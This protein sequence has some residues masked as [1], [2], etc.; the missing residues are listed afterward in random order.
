[1][2]EHLSLK[3][4]ARRCSEIVEVLK[5]SNSLPSRLYITM[6]PPK[7]RTL[8]MALLE[9]VPMNNASLPV[10]TNA[11]RL[12]KHQI[13]ALS[14]EILMPSRILYL[15]CFIVKSTHGYS[16]HRRRLLTGQSLYAVPLRPPMRGYIGVMEGPTQGGTQGLVL[17]C[18]W[19]WYL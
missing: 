19:R 7:S 8:E 13:R 9:Q 3:I 5:R 11:R 17:P 2:S 14:S 16:S 18:N 12:I 15:M 6:L 1:M 10:T 4:I